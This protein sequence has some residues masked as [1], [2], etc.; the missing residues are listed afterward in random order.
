MSVNVELAAGQSLSS[1]QV[2]VDYSH[3]Y[4]VNY[5]GVKS[6]V[7][8]AMSIDY[9]NNLLSSKG[10]T[11]VSECIDGIAPVGYNPGGCLNQTIGQVQLGEVILGS[12]LAGPLTGLL[13]NVSFRV[14]GLGTSVLTPEVVQVAYPYYDP[15][16]PGFFSIQYVPILKQAAIFAN[17]GPAAFYNYQPDYAKDSV[18]SPSILP[19][20]PALFD[21]S[22]SFVANDSSTQITSYSWDLGDAGTST[23]STVVHTYS[24]PGNYNVTLTVT[25]GK[26]RTNEL[27]REVSVI[28]ALGNLSIT[29]EDRSGTTVVGGIL[30]KLFN[31]S[32]STS[33]FL[34]K[35]INGVG[36]TTFNNLAPGSYLLTF[37]GPGWK[38]T[39]RT[40][41][42]MPGWTTTDTVYL[43]GIPIPPDYSGLIYLGATITGIGVVA[44]AFFFQKRKTSAA[45]RKTQTAKKL[46]A[47]S[48][49]RQGSSGSRK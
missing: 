13:F 27:A 36:Q 3:P 41:N 31:S 19:N 25:D 47:A 8:Q 15:S 20:Q 30:V 40:E 35:T 7:L 39:T 46:G 34:N 21:A 48:A 32:S 9:S 4:S 17:K 18:V 42:V 5:Q 33:P 26:S 16:N 49:G 10:H 11:P 37:S 28:P 23:T 6:G 38:D 43:Y 44:A 22:D 2:R 24:Q 12:A 45:K 1:F 14:A 29:V